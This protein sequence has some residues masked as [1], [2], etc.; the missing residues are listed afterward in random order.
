MCGTHWSPGP[1]PLPRVR[2]G[3]LCGEDDLR[4]VCFSKLFEHWEVPARFDPG[5]CWP[6]TVA[7]STLT[8]SAFSWSWEGGHRVV[9]EANSLP[10]SIAVTNQMCG[11]HLSTLGWVVDKLVVSSACA[12][13]YLSR[14]RCLAVRN[15][16][17][18]VAASTSRT[19][20]SSCTESFKCTWEIRSIT[21][22]SIS[23][24]APSSPIRCSCY[25][26]SR[27]WSSALDLSLPQLVRFSPLGC[28]VE[29][30]R[31]SSFNAAETLSQ[32]L[33]LSK[34]AY[35]FWDVDVHN[36][37]APVTPSQRPLALNA[38]A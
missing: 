35:F 23:S 29:D 16:V 24:F 1:S 15:R 19:R 37:G 13:A 38:R 25:A 5:G 4:L 36:I 2:H 21:S 30:A 27:L 9:L 12:C 18:C 11:L 31:N 6:S 14:F 8:A 17:Q 32:S 34:L 10:L 20:D 33:E 28:L 3:S 22:F 26:V 7:W